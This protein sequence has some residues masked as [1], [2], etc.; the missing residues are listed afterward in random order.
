MASRPTNFGKTWTPEDN[1]QLLVAFK[2]GDSAP[3]IAND[4]GRNVNGTIGQLVRLRKVKNID[5]KIY[6]GGRLWYDNTRR[7]NTP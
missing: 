6:K 4:L 3:D 5:G 7:D 2:R 1:H